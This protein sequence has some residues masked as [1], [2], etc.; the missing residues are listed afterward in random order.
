MEEIIQYD[1]QL[2]LMV[3]G[4]DSLFMD[5]LILTLTNAKT[6]IPLYIGLFY[7]V[8]KTNKNVRDV[9][10]ILAVAGLC[11]L[12]AGA[13]DDGIVK[14]LVARWRPTHDPEIGSLVDVVNGYRGESTVS[15]QPM[16]PTRSASPSSSLC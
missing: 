7:V 5:Y 6:W 10:L 9:L 4:S 1:K 3:N 14:P 15:S 16:P 13:V 12:L 11:Y 8:L 2:L